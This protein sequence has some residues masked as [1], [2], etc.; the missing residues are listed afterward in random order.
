MTLNSTEPIIYTK[1][2]PTNKKTILHFVKLE[3]FLRRYDTVAVR[4]ALFHNT[5]LE[6]DRMLPSNK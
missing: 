4:I 1:F 3:L 6:E 2:K 5:F